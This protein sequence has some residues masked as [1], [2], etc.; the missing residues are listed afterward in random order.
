MQQPSPQPNVLAFGKTANLSTEFWI[1]LLLTGIGSGLCAGLLM[2]LLRFVQHHAWSYT[3]GDFLSGVSRTSAEHR[4]VVLALAGVLTGSVL[5]LLQRFSKERGGDLSGSIWFQSGR[6]PPVRTTVRAILSIVI[7]GLGVSLGR[8]EA[9]KQAGALIASR[10]SFWRRLSPFERRVLTA[11]GA[12]AGMAAVYNV[13]LG[14][15]LFILEV[16]LGTLSITLALPSLICCFT[17]TAVAWI[18]LPP[19]PTYVIP[20]YG[21]SGQELALAAVM[22]PLIGIATVAYIRAVVW[23][24]GHKPKGWRLL[25]T[26]VVVCTGLG[27]LSIYFPELLGNGRNVAQEA[28]RDDLTLP[29]LTMLVL[30]K[31]LVTIACMGTSAPGGLFTPT[32]TYGSL[33]GGLVGRAWAVIWSDSSPIC[34]APGSASFIGAGAVLAAATQGPLSATVLILELTHHIG[35]QIVPLLIAVSGATLVS[36]KLDSRSIYS[37]RLHV[38][39]PGT[40]NSMEAGATTA[41]DLPVSHRFTSIQSATQYTVVLEHLLAD[42]SSDT[43]YVVNDE[44]QFVGAITRSSLPQAVVG[45]STHLQTMTAA[46]LATPLKPL[47]SDMSATEAKCRFKDN[48]QTHLPVLECGSELL[49]G[50]VLKTDLDV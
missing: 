35:N 44:N 28:F 18:L 29:M 33:L 14:G 43:L 3:S 36:Q 49:L 50:V 15:A 24:H 26:A 16:L 22:G 23:A 41:G 5:W 21:M 13:P 31:P 34:F 30:L 46:D 42:S 48:D 8:E 37:G 17:A 19:E 2:K 6:L 12:G 4:V 20:S 47:Y 11:C 45:F 27:L 9:P 40:G 39:G 25:S 10:L 1:L 7:V 32:I 38:Q